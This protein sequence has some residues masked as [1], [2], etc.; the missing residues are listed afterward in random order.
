MVSGCLEMAFHKRAI[1]TYHPQKT[2]TIDPPN[3]ERTRLKVVRFAKVGRELREIITRWA[4]T[5]SLKS[6]ALE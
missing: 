1:S 2:P 5:R 6:D 4:R 3:V